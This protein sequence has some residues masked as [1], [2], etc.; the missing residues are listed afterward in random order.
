MSIVNRICGANYFV[1]FQD[2]IGYVDVKSSP[3]YFY[4]NRN[5]GISFN[6]I[7]TPIPFEKEL[8]NVGGAMDLKS[9]KFTTPQD[10]IYAFSFAGFAGFP[11]SS[12][13][14]YLKVRLLLNGTTMAKGQSDEGG[15]AGEFEQFSFQSTL[16]LKAGD[17]I[18]LE[19]YSMSTGAY[20]W[21]DYFTQFSGYILEENI[22]QSLSGM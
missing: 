20:L 3:V 5:S 17:Q 14:V 9:G 10:G 21:G 15:T 1:G 6:T 18:W 2:R 12:S 11:A 4:V 16:N 7:N 19:I 8:L 22:T 13:A